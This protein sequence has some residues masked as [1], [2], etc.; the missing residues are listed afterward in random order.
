M[1]RAGRATTRVNAPIGLPGGPRTELTGDGRVR[2]R[3]LPGTPRHTGP[4]HE[5]VSYQAAWH[6]GRWTGP[7][8]ITVFPVASWAH[9][10]E[11]ALEAPAS[12]Q[13][14]LMWP[15]NRLRVLAEGLVTAL[16]DEAERTAALQRPAGHREPATRGA[17]ASRLMFFSAGSSPSR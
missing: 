2:L 8:T 14:R 17:P 6:A 1:D 15:G 12:R 13:G 10:L 16:R 9:D 11:I 7:A 3:I 4:P 5:A